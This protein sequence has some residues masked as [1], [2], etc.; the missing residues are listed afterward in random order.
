LS[1]LKNNKKKKKE[2]NKM[3]KI[4][5]KAEKIKLYLCVTLCGFAALMLTGAFIV[6]PT[7][8]ID[9][10]VLIALAEILAF[11]GSLAGIN[12]NYST[13][14]REIELKYNSSTNKNEGE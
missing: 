12:Y 5:T 14:M 11:S 9:Q 3:E 7:G 13:K 2:V 10:S 6:P 4:F 8:I 1:C